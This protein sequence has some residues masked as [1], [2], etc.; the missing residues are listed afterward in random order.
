MKVYLVRTISFFSQGWEVFLIERIIIRITA[1]TLHSLFCFMHESFV[2]LFSRAL[3]LFCFQN[4]KQ[5]K[6]L[7]INSSFLM[8]VAWTNWFS[9]TIQ[10]SRLVALVEVRRSKSWER[11]FM[12]SSLCAQSYLLNWC[13]HT[14]RPML[15]SI[16]NRKMIELKSLLW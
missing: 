12:N 8:K 15:Y 13:F 1:D 16:A 3:I 7:T 2:L 14:I 6:I 5:E 10:S 9:W 11:Y 4:E